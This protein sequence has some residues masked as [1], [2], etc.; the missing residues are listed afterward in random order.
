MLR[1]NLHR[2]TSHGLLAR[3]GMGSTPSTRS[4]AVRAAAAA[5][6]GYPGSAAGGCGPGTGA[7]ASGYLGLAGPGWDYPAAGQLAAFA[8][9]FR[10]QR[11]RSRACPHPGAPGYAATAL[12]AS[13]LALRTDASGRRRTHRRR[14]LAVGAAPRRP[15]VDGPGLLEL[16]GFL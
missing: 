7:A 11:Q 12:G 13:A 15:G 6:A 16:W 5:G 14:P 8:S 1:H 3:Y 9:P 4:Q 10:Q 2:R